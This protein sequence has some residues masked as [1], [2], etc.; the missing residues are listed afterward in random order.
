MG[1]VERLAATIAASRSGIPGARRK[2][3][4]ELALCGFD[5]ASID[6]ATRR[7]R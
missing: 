2:G 3:A 4:A 5:R 1:S 7:G 6:G